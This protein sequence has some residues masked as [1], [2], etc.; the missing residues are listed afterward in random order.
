MA[1]TPR[2]P[3]PAIVLF[4]AVALGLSLAY[5]GLFPLHRLAL[6]PFDPGAGIVGAARG[7][8]PA[9]AALI[10]A[11]ATGGRAGLAELWSR[12]RRWRIS[13]RL[14]AL[15]FLVP[16]VGQLAVLSVAAFTGSEP[17]APTAV[18]IGRLVLVFF[19]FALVDGPVGEEIGW[20]GFLLPRL[21]ERGGLIGASAL[22]G[23]VWFVWHLPLFHADGSRA[24]TPAFLAE[25]L[26]LNVALSFVHTW[27]F[28]RSGG[29]TP[30]AILFHTAGNYLVFL[31][32]SIFPGLRQMEEARL[33][34]V[35]AVGFFA[36]LAAIDLRAHPVR[37]GFARGM[38]PIVRTTENG[39][40]MDKTQFQVVINHE[41]QY[42]VWPAGR[43][44][45]P[46]WKAVGRKGTKEQC[47]T[48]IEEVW[49]DMRPTDRSRLR[50]LVRRL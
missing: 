41:E 17:L 18:P 3:T 6:L 30:L 11:W 42:S 48:Y 32:M 13:P 35:I 36:V 20:R 7:Y 44:L 22:V 2:D 34:Y 12:L 37:W 5:W 25:Y 38:E 49:T 31:D 28:V 10:A 29:S 39:G 26:A 1:R 27:F 40:A 33:V 23:A 46:G 16:V 4:V 45:Q 47:L 8:G 19:V 21:L 50:D 24:L 15:A 14:V 43:P 9:L